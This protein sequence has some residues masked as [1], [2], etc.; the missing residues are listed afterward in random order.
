STS[1]GLTSGGLMHLEWNPGGGTEIYATSDL[2]SIDI[3]QYGNVDNLFAI[4]DNG[5]DVCKVSQ[6]QI[7]SAVP[8]S[9]TAAGDVS[10][11]ND[12]VFTNQTAAKIISDGPLTIQSGEAF[13]NLDLVL[14]P[15][16]SGS[17]IIDDGN[18]LELYSAQN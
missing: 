10:I 6:S 17:V 11:A 4:D 1:T 3:G 7:E 15:S 14:K 9:F 13:E 18:N 16:G 12:L 2:F 5:N 8:H